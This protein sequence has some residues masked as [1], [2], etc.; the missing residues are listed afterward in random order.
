MEGGNLMGPPKIPPL[1]PRLADTI[2]IT[3]VFSGPSELNGNGIAEQARADELGPA[4]LLP[5]LSIDEWLA[6][7]LPEPD[8]LMG[9][10]LSTTNRT[11]L[12]APTGVGKTGFVMALGAHVSDG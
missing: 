4:E 9:D 12:V 3:Q 8:L 11:L 2:K 1:H 10:W 5:P 6:R 7:D